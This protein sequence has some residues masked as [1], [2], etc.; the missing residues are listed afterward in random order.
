MKIP[1]FKMFNDQ[2]KGLF[3]IE[4]VHHDKAGPG[5]DSKACKNQMG[6][7]LLATQR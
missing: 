1:T 6:V 2:T 5:Y 7:D 4:D 3:F